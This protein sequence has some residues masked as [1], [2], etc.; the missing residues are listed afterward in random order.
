MRVHFCGVLP[1][2]EQKHKK[3]TDKQKK[4]KKKQTSL[5]P[6]K[7]LLLSETTTYYLYWFTYTSTQLPVRDTTVPGSGLHTCIG[8]HI[9]ALNYL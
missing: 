5:T 2:P 3:W 1:N 6:A 8:L 4:T 9:L 7:K